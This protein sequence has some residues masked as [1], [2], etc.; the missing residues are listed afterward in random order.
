MRIISLLLVI[1]SINPSYGFEASDNFWD[2]GRG[3]F[4]VGISGSSPSG[5]TWNAAF[6]RSMAAWSDVSSFDF[7]AVDDYLDPCIDRGAGQFGDGSTGVD[8]GATVCGTA[9]GGNTL[10]VTLTA[11]QCQNPQC[12]GGFTIT[13]ADIVFNSAETWDVYGGPIRTDGTAEFE[14][15]ALHELGHALGLDH[16]TA[17]SAI[18]NAFVSDIDSLQSDDVAGI[19]FIYDGGSPVASVANIYGLSLVSPANSTL[20]GPSDSIELSG[21]LSSNDDQLSGK[22]IDLYQYTFSND[23]AV[24]IQLVSQEFDPLL[25][26]ARVSAT[27]AAIPA[28]TFV[29]D[30]SGSGNN[31]RITQN[32]QA[33][34]YWLGV[35][36]NDDGPQGSYGISIASNTSSPASSFE[37]FTSVYGVDVL[38][39]PNPNI[40]G[41]LDSS[42]FTFNSKF[43]DLVQIE[44]EA[45]ATVSI[46]LNSVAFDTTLLLV[47][48]IGGQIGSL[49]LQ[50]DDGGSGTNSQIQTTLSPGTYWLGVTSFD[51]NESGNYDIS[52][53]LVIP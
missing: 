16:S 10:A 2:I 7:I 38:V 47:D 26:L 11:G 21:T 32:I 12:T 20:N 51:P 27:Q 41:N 24:D 37:S 1:L 5:G 22:A 25:Y 36:S 8:F 46:D 29:D 4:H 14:R 13:D 49:A 23:S 33:G 35:T 17:D 19:N 30:D 6:K 44:I 48:I 52:I 39:N 34:T 28:F 9:F 40:S 43:L 45:T 50:D 3:V 53:S 42:D 15:V 31:S 18:M